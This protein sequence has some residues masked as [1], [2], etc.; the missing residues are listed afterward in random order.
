[1][2]A[3]FSLQ[4]VG[5]RLSMSALM[6]QVFSQTVASLISAIRKIALVSQE[7]PEPRAEQAA[8]HVGDR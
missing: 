8:F 4:D 3:G 2:L 6:R 5:G 7:F 1:V